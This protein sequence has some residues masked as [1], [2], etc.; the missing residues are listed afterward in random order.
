MNTNYLNNIG[1]TW[2]NLIEDTT[3]KVSGI[4][5]SYLATRKVYAKEITNATKTYGPSDGTSKIG[6]MY[7]SDYGFA[8]SPSAWTT[9][10]NNYDVNDAK[11]TSI[12]TIN[13]MYM[14]Y[15]DWTITPSSS[16]GYYVF[17]LD[18]GGFVVTVSAGYGCGSRPVLYLDASVYKIDGDGSLNNPYIVGM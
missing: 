1:T 7:V 5:D 16:S 2:S 11:G 6:L 10:L 3:W 9:T 18:Y 13:W 14:G 15:N 17:Y 8:A 12:K 4:H